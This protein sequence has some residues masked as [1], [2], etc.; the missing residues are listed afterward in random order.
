MSSETRTGTTRLAALDGLRGIACLVVLLHHCMLSIPVFADAYFDGANSRATQT[1]GE[2]LLTWS[3]LHLFWEGT[4]AVWAFFVLSGFVLTRQVLVSPRFTWRSYYPQRII[5]LY[6][7]VFAA[8]LLAAALV[9]IFGNAPQGASPSDWIARRADSMNPSGLLHDLTLLF[10]AGAGISPLWSLQWEV[11][12]SLLLPLFV[13]AVRARRDA[14]GQLALAAVPAAIF[15]VFALGGGEYLVVFLVGAA[16]A[17][18]HDRMGV[19]VSAIA[20]RPR[21]AAG[22][23]AVAVA[24]V[25]IL[26]PAR[27]TLWFLHLPGKMTMVL[28]V[29][30]AAVIVLLVLYLPLVERGLSRRPVLWAGAVSFSLYLVHEPILVSS[31]RAFGD[32]HLWVA[33]PLAA[34]VA[35]AVAEVFRRFVEGP[36]ATLARHAGRTIAGWQPASGW[37]TTPDEVRAP[38]HE[39]WRVSAGVGNR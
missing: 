34:A 14:T 24:W 27:W 1:F 29:S 20:E 12:F 21:V 7:P 9:T 19:S 10:G 6:L 36:S 25:V 11:W 5:R 22:V 39:L 2:Y 4:G 35:L 17:R 33:L 3:P 28:S 15:A 13:F 8:V 37:T 16:L 30:A 31:V 38:A 23:I 32:R 26:L 18:L